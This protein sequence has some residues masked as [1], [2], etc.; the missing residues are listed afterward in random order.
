M[1]SVINELDYVMV[2]TKIN[3]NYAMVYPEITDLKLYNG[4]STYQNLVQNL[5]VYLSL[6]YSTYLVNTTRNLTVR[7]KII[8]G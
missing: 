8:P 7:D 5:K 1:Y 4:V 6:Q 2:S 3:F